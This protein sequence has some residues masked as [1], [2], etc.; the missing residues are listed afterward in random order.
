MQHFEIE[1]QT[2]PLTHFGKHSKDLQSES[3]KLLFMLSQ[4]NPTAFLL[5]I[6]LQLDLHTFP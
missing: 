2:E 3:N 1:F 6:W 5:P 4:R